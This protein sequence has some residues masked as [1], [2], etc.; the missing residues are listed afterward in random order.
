M[1][2]VALSLLLMIFIA[3]IA[4][5][6]TAQTL[7]APVHPMYVAVDRSGTVLVSVIG[8]DTAQS[9][10]FTYSP[11]GTVTYIPAGYPGQIAPDSG[12][13]VYLADRNEGTIKALGRDGEQ[14]VNFSPGKGY[15]LTGAIA[16]DNAG[17]IYAGAY[18]EG[19]ATNDG[20]VLKF[21]GNESMIAKIGDISAIKPGYPSSIDVDKNGSLFITDHSNTVTCIFSNGSEILYSINGG[22]S[23]SEALD[24][25]TDRRGNIYIADTDNNRIVKL[26]P[27]GS[28]SATIKGCGNMTFNHP[29]G[30]AVDVMD[31][32][33]VADTY[34]QRVVWFSNDYN[35]TGNRSFDGLQ[36][37]L[38][39]SYSMPV[40]SDNGNA[41]YVPMA[42]ALIVA[43]AIVVVLLSRKEK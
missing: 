38:I 40:K 34:N 25:V 10:I 20:L 39:A 37:G 33:Y 29:T 36:C 43:C 13:R 31:R 18:R 23:M 41:D 42:I 5:P 9:F 3:F 16:V 21:S 7:T 12:D 11:N 24:A 2:G 22:I 14:Y 8:N 28:V 4:C 26:R 17:N 6:V 35:Y 30:I 19:Y 32:V 27:D 1:D 15:G